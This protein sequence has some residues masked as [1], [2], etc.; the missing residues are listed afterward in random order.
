MHLFRQW[1]GP[2]LAISVKLV[3]THAAVSDGAVHCKV[4]SA[5]CYEQDLASLHMTPNPRTMHRWLDKAWPSGFNICG[6]SS[7]E[8][9]RSFAGG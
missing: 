9:A 1:P 5:L 4:C 3:C 8:V 6:G 2:V 7:R